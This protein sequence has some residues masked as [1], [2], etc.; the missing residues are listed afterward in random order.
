MREARQEAPLRLIRPFYPEGETPA[1]LYLLNTTAGVLEGDR[2]E[3][4]L[5]LGKKTHLLI[6]TPAATRVHPAPSGESGQRA[7]FSLG[8]EAILEY[9][10][11]PLLPYAGASFHQETEIFVE[12]G[13]ILFFLDLLAPGR[14]ARGE[15]FAY[16][17]YENRLK[18]HDA[19]GTLAQESFC[20]APESRALGAPGV[21]E[22]YSH[23]GSLYLIC[24]ENTRQA[25]LQSFH[26]EE[27]PG[28]FW[29]GTLLSRRGLSVKAL[30][31]DTPAIQDFFL[32]LWARFR[33]E[34]LG[35]DAPAIRRY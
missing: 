8:A 1:H 6:T 27:A 20:L 32:K 18:I 7:V 19:E 28:V 12:E 5:R 17:R 15:A 35:R 23:L 25:L 31:C 9:L 10:P 16:R 21:M 29:G 30:S 14:S 26:L 34:I 4:T 2:L 24:P 13:A 11:E 22:G 3:L 33:K